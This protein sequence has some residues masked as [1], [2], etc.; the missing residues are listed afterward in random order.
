MAAAMR[1]TRAW[2]VRGAWRLQTGS[3]RMAA[4]ICGTGHK[5][6]GQRAGIVS[7]AP[8]AMIGCWRRVRS[9]GGQ[10]EVGM[11]GTET[12]SVGRRITSGSGGCAM[13]S[14][15]GAIEA[16]MDGAAM[17][18]AVTV[19]MGGITATGGGMGTGVGMTAT[20]AVAGS[21]AMTSVTT[22][23]TLRGIAS[24]MEMVGRERID[25]IRGAGWNGRMSGGERI[26]GAESGHIKGR[27]REMPGKGMGTGVSLEMSGRER[28]A[29]A[30]RGMSITSQ[31][32]EEAIQRGAR[33]IGG[34]VHHLVRTATQDLLVREMHDVYLCLNE[35]SLVMTPEETLRKTLRRSHMSVAAYFKKGNGI[36][37]WMPMFSTSKW[38]QCCQIGTRC[39]YK[40]WSEAAQSQTSVVT[41]VT[42]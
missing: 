36:R 18:E 33:G 31:K 5:T 14:T 24:R 40:L 13:T 16:A 4:R 42:R 10:N 1:A 9:A 27:V 26:G 20:G 19:A 6:H 39:G 37:I 35:W 7:V 28:L 17:H 41:V 30:R 2:A 12:G 29:G 38:L 34:R 25:R 3:L 11:I 8:A 23:G 21:G 22:A 32:G 15:I